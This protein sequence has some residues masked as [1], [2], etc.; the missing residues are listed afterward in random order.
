MARAVTQR[1]KRAKK[2]EKLRSH[3]YYDYSLLILVMFI[4]AFGLVMIYSSSSYTAQTSS[5]FNND[6]AYFLKRQAASAIIGIAVMLFVSKLNYRL[7][8][9]HVPIIRITYASLLFLV[10]CILQFVV[11]F[12]GVEVNGAK[13][14]L[15]LNFVQIQPS[16]ITKVAV[17]VFASYIIYLAPRIM[18]TFRGYVKV[19]IFMAI[20][21]ALVGK[22]NMS[23]AIVLFLIA[24]GICFVASRKKMFYVVAFAAGS[25]L[26]GLYLLLGAGFRME[27]INIWLN[28]ETH[29]KG[30]QILQGLYA[31]ASGG[32]FGTGLGESMQ[33]LG[34]IPESYND[35]IFSIVCEELGLCGAIIVVIL[36]ILLLWRIFTVAINAPDLYG[37]LLC[38]G[39]L[40]H[41]AVQVIINIAVVTNSIPSTG[42][43]LPFISYGGTSVVI[44]LAEMGMVLSVSNQ[45]KGY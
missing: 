6:A 20:P 30:F 38:V 9:K 43:P 3:N 18:D 25:V 24:T 26:A 8:L 37:S 27:R 7:L 35:M 13:R 44:L 28:V 11:L 31:I 15:D 45:I 41:I 10:A 23:T 39:V 16:E 42:I 2:L 32:L 19:M 4:V 12:I 40:V 21:I 29:P 33:K 22:E 5:E 14:W 17:I 34:F 1:A 36:F